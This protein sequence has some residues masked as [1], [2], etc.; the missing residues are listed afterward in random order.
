M[1]EQYHEQEAGLNSEI[2]DLNEKIQMTSEK[3]MKSE[4]ERDLLNGIITEKE[5]QINE[6][7]FLIFNKLPSEF[8]NFE[9]L[10]KK[11]TEIHNKMKSENNTLG[12]DYQETLNE[13]KEM[14]KIYKDAANIDICRTDSGY[15][16]IIFKHLIPEN[17][18][19][20]LILELKNQ[21]KVIEV[22]PK[23]NISHLEEH[24]EKSRNC[25][26]F[27]VSLANEFIKFYNI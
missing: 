22:F 26:S 23:I 17:K 7:E 3:Y 5:K 21:Y 6:I 18:D 1:L 20:Y 2:N 27:I 4:V 11:E 13:L 15:L 8:S 9:F 14:I 10:L 25:T 24:L 12:V 19:A 16:K